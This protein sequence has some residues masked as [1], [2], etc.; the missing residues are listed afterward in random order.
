MLVRV[1][2][3]SNALAALAQQVVVSG[4]SEFVLHVGQLLTEMGVPSA[5]MVLL[6]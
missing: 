4:P 6:D 1:G 5:S 2:R 3:L